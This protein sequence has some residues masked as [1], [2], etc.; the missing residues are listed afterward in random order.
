MKRFETGRFRVWWMCVLVAAA[1]ACRGG[2]P[3]PPAEVPP[4]PTEA[5]P[6]E[7]VRTAAP[8]EAPAATE[9]PTEAATAV[10]TETAEPEPEVLDVGATRL[11]EVDGMLL[12]YVPAGEFLMGA[13]DDDELA[14]DDER[15]QHTVYLDA[16]WIDQ[17]EV[18]NAMYAQCVAAGGCEAQ[19]LVDSQTRTGYFEDPAYANY[20]TTHVSWEEA[21]AYCTW[22]G[23]R[24]PTEAEW[25][26]AARGTDGRLWPWGNAEP[27]ETRLNFLGNE[28]G[29]TT[30]V[31]AYPDGASPYGALDM[32]GNLYEWTADWY[33]PTYYAESPSENPVGP[34]EDPD[35]RHS[36]RGGYFDTSAKYVRVTE[37]DGQSFN[38]PPWIGFRCAAAAE[39]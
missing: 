23:R 33:S 36:L 4:Q 1:L 17:T 22:A 24:L 39:E 15:P 29:D 2:A 27:D 32:A 37:R 20:P 34:A 19:D 11:S 21:V 10:P 7:A 14:D 18:T 30:E 5:G 26:K 6:T 13:A 35:E 8:T 25:E 31:G 38:R 28:G 16:F 3:A 9:A 12:M